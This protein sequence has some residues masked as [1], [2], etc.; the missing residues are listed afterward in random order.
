MPKTGILLPIFSLPSKYG[1]GDF[2]NEAY[3][4]IDILSKNNI[5]FWE[6]LPITATEGLPYSP[7]SYYALNTAYISIDKLIEDGL[8]S[9]ANTIQ[10][11]NRIVYNDFK[12]KYYK[13]AY[14]KF[15]QK[16][17]TNRNEKF[18]KF[19][20]N[21]EIIHYAKFMN[22]QT[23]EE[24]DYYIFLQFILDKQWNKLRKYAN[25]KNVK[26]IGD[27]PIYPSY[28]SCEV[29]YNEKYYEV[30]KNGMKYIAGAPPDEYNANGQIW[31]NPV[32]NIENI[33]NDKYI[34]LLN[35]F[36][37][38]MKRFDVTRLDHFRGYDS[39]FK[40]PSNGTAKDGCYENGVGTEFFNELMKISKSENYIVEDLGDIRKETEE[41][42]NKYQ[43]IGQEILI[44]LFNFKEQK[45]NEMKDNILLYTGNHDTSTTIG[46]YNNL[47]NE[48]KSACDMILKKLGFSNKN[49]NEALIEICKNSSAEI[50]MIPVQDILG[51]DDTSR[52]NIPGSE[53]DLNWSWKMND[54]I[55]FR[56]KVKIL[57]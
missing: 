42:R 12:E 25:S 18:N 15:K 24:I 55:S 47:Q 8:I 50:I 54:F 31:W 51:L 19:K 32:Y 22:N 13:C 28:K 36:K 35:R 9:E 7:I 14:E 33:K 4:F 5:S 57:K 52:I 11:S 1:I 16:N 21:T 49:I 29:Q 37:E 34:Y 38:F 26:I 6:V 53:S 39:F 2:G 48:E 56:E 43:L 44:Y 30:N 10:A 41:L 45:I 40:I 20:D 17:V 46:W 27:M 23:G 3:E